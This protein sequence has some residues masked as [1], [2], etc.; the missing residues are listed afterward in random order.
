MDRK[1]LSLFPTGLLTF[2]QFPPPSDNDFHIPPALARRRNRERKRAG[3]LNGG[4]MVIW[5]SSSSSSSE[6]WKDYL[7]G[8]LKPVAATAVVALA[9][10]LS[11]IQRI[12]LEKEMAYSI[13]RAF[14]QLSIIGFVLEFIF[15]QKNAG[16]ILLAYLFMVNK[17]F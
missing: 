6:F 14:L 11:F 2:T 3:H 10:A 7:K 1:T 15:T 4:E 16:W 17:N 9:I 12:G 8:M 13:F 5:L